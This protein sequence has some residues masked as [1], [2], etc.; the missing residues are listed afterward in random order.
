MDEN[1]DSYTFRLYVSPPNSEGAGS[2]L[3]VY[4]DTPDKR[5]ALPDPFIREQGARRNLEVR[6]LIAEIIDK[7]SDEPNY[8]WTIFGS[9]INLEFRVQAILDDI[10]TSR[11]S[12]LRRFF[13]ECWAAMA[14]EPNEPFRAVFI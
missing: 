2:T 11:K 5:K 13:G 14:R 3:T 6:L 10:G 9:E 8:A 7:E 1:H 4:W 12:D